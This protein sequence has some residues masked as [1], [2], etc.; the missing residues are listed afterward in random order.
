MKFSCL[1]G[2]IKFCLSSSEPSTANPRA[3][4]FM[5]SII[6]YFDKLARA[7]GT[8]WTI[9]RGGTGF[10]LPAVVY[11]WTPLANQSL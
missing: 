8:H 9:F 4:D 11:S 1:H 6:T 3:H 7:S 10:I 5:E 2:I